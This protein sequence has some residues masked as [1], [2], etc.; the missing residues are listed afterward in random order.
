MTS[1]RPLFIGGVPNSGATWLTDRLGVEGGL[2]PA[3]EAD[4]VARV[5]FVY[6]TTR[7]IARNQALARAAADAVR[8]ANGTPKRLISG[9]AHGPR[10]LNLEADWLSTRTAVLIDELDVGLGLYAIRE[11]LL[12]VLCR[13]AELD[14]R[15]HWA[16]K[17]TLF[18]HMLPQLM[19]VFPDMCFVH[20]VREMTPEGGPLYEAWLNNADQFAQAHPHH[21]ARVDYT[22]LLHHMEDTIQGILQWATR[23]QPAP[24]RVVWGPSRVAS[25]A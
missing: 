14:G 20:V 1:L 18:P 23:E 12:D 22:D 24:E 8:Y 11:F 6:Q 13:H 10:H 2:S 16:C 7:G 5:L 9:Y 21:Y 4:L 25:A 3:Y 19:A 17:A 15:L